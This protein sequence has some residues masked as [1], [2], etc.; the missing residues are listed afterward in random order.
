MRLKTRVPFNTTLNKELSQELD[1]LAKETRI[2]KSK[3]TDEAVELLLKKHKR[4][5]ESEE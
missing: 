3:L 4:G 2:P 5:V 1:Q